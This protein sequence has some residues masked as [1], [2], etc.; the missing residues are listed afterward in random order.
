MSEEL[1]EKKI[2]ELESFLSHLAGERRMSPATIR[3]YRLAV[4]RYLEWLGESKSWSEVEPRTARSYAIELQ[5]SY[6]RRTLHNRVAGIRAFYR[7]HRERQAV[8]RN[9]FSSLSLPKLEKNLPRF[10]T[11][12]QIRLFLEG[13][14]RLLKEESISDFEAWRDR[15][16]LELLY[17]AGLRISELVG[18]DVGKLELGRGLIR[19]LGKG[20]KERIVPI[21]KVASHCVKQHLHLS[22][23]EGARSGPVVIHASGKGVSTRWLQLR[24][25]KYLALAELPQDLS[26]HKLRH[27]FATH[28][29]DG[30]ADIRS[31]QE[32]LGHAS[33]S[34]T[35]IYT[36]TSIG[37]LQEVYRQ[38][39]PRA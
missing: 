17:G 31:V 7:Y 19:V 36:H 4:G 27:S 16:A 14:M 15:A 20:N 32:L 1:A 21:G 29:L 37:R 13:P 12:T 28:L 11:E 2:P 25:K 3:N 34:T 30:G 22:H 26:P 18:A 23:R 33:L 38:A 24:M 9:P 8:P 6:S 5:R 39:H 10:L 35:Q